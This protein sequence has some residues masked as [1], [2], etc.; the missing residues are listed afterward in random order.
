MKK[1]EKN[2]V[3]E[4]RGIASEKCDCNL[5][6]TT[7]SRCFLL[8]QVIEK[9]ARDFANIIEDWAMGFGRIPGVAEESS[10]AERL[11]VWEML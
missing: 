3:N 5:Y 11:G 10:I 8:H 9:H 7:C 4:L 2:I 6:G 1:E